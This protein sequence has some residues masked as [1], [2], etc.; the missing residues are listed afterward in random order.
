MTKTLDGSESLSCRLQHGSYCQDLFLFASLHWPQFLSCEWVVNFCQATGHSFLYP[1]LQA[2]AVCRERGHIINCVSHSRKASTLHRDPQR[3]VL[4]PGDLLSADSFLQRGSSLSHFQLKVW[5]WKSS[6]V[7]E[8]LRT[9]KNSPLKKGDVWVLLFV[10]CS[11]IMT[12]TAI[13]WP[14]FQSSDQGISPGLN[15]LFCLRLL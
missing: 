13:F 2:L 15:F 4:Y 8:I 6:A 14:Q 10:T 9:E 5:W 3:Q 7:C 11:D 12:D 1:H